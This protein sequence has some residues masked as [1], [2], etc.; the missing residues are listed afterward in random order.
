VRAQRKAGV[1]VG[2][3]LDPAQL[4][5][6]A[7]WACPSCSPCD[8]NADNGFAKSRH[9]PTLTAHPGSQPLVLHVELHVDAVIFDQRAVRILNSQPELHAC[10]EILACPTRCRLDARQRYLQ[11]IRTLEDRAPHPKPLRQQPVFTSRPR[12][13]PFASPR[14]LIKPSRRPTPDAYSQS[15]RSPLLQS[16][17]TGAMRVSQSL[18]LCQPIRFIS[19]RNLGSDRRL[20][21][22][23]SRASSIRSGLCS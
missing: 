1:R 23:G 17:S 18:A 8:S 11:R 4:P 19:S 15:P 22:E 3:S 7:G 21:K 10:L 20:A 2:R 5:I 12:S 16:P 9:R 13:A 14:S 6:F